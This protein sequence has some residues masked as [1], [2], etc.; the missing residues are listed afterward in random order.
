MDWMSNV[1][2]TRT[3]MKEERGGECFLCDNNSKE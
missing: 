2:L 1:N 3:I